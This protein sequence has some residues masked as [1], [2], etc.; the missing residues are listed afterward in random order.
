MAFWQKSSDTGTTE[1]NAAAI[2]K[3]THPA[4]PTASDVTNCV[5]CTKRAKPSSIY[6]SDECIRKHASSTIVNAQSSKVDKSKDRPPV[7]SSP[8]TASVGNT[9]ST[10]ESHIVRIFILLCSL[11]IDI[12]I[13]FR[14]YCR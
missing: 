2:P 9:D 11:H 7:A 4:A 8:A 14:L 1:A 12:N 3:I 13:T 6:C 5:V 10:N